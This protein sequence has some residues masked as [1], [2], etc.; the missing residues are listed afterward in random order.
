MYTEVKEFRKLVFSRE[1]ESEPGVES[2]VIIGLTPDGNETSM[3]FEHAGVG[4]RSIHN[5]PEGW[6][7]TF[8]KLKRI[9][10]QKRI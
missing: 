4:C 3:Q 9:L 2:L 10:N 8:E 1:W 6:T 5:Y 7:M